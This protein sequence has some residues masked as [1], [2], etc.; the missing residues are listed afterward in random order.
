MVRKY[1]IIAEKDS[2]GYYIIPERIINRSDFLNSISYHPKHV[3][4][5]KNL[6]FA[7]ICIVD[8]NREKPSTIDSWGFGRITLNNV[9]LY[10]NTHYLDEKNDI[11]YE[12]DKEDE[13]V[14]LVRYLKI[15]RLKYEKN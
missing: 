14:S 9:S 2:Q 11:I 3:E 15:K 7:I 1:K 12:V 4:P 13:M 6:V 5:M 10:Y 8:Q